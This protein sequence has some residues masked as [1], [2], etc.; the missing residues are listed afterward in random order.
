RR[1]AP[2]PLARLQPSRSL[3][4]FA[5]VLAALR[6][7]MTRR[8]KM[9]YAL[10]DDGSA[11]LEVAI[12]NELYEQHRLRLREDQLIIVQGKVSHDD[13][14]GGLRLTA[15]VLYDLQLARESRAHSLRITL[16]GDADAQRLRQLLNPYRADPENGLPGVPVEVQLEREGYRCLMRLGEDWR[17]R[18]SDTLLEQLAD[19]VKPESLEITYA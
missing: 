3:Q 14:S 4:W 18:M 5:G 2:T 12:F 10:L 16:N 19:W 11:Q 17:V 6:P 8:G 7:R 15:D 13:F 1:F 9:L